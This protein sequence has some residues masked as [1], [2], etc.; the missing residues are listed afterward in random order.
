[1]SRYGASPLHLL[2]HLALFALALWALGHVL[3]FRGA[4]DWVVWLVGGALVHD[5][6]F[7]PAYTLL[8]RLAGGR[9]PATWI[10]HLRVP[11]VVSGVLL[12]VW[13]PLILRVAPGNYEL[14][15]GEPPGPERLRDWL[16]VTGALFA[17]SAVLY[18]VRSRRQHPRVG[19]AE[20]DDPAR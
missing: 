13:F 4:R 15:A 12:L 20:H 17:A 16:L 11:A 2:G 6:L 9:R 3:D 8:D 1:M 19:G 5:L 7:L 10:N 18:A 14:V